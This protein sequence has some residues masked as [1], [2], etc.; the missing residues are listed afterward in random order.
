[1]CRR[2][3]IVVPLVM[4]TGGC[5]TLANQSSDGTGRPYGGLV[6][7]VAVVSDGPDPVSAVVTAADEMTSDGQHFFPVWPFTLASGF[8]FLDVPLSAVGDTIFLPWDAVNTMSGHRRT[9]IGSLSIQRPPP[10]T[11]AT[12]G[13]DCPPSRSAESD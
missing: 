13:P 8:A 7:S 9:L 2:A 1:M 6:N 5:G 3:L 11:P 12:Q 10:D 4:L